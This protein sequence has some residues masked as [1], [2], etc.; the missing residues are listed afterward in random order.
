VDLLPE[1]PV[2][3]V[4]TTENADR[5]SPERTPGAER[6]LPLG[7]TFDDVLLL[8]A[9][10]DVVPS[11]ADT[12]TRRV[13]RSAIRDAGYRMRITT[14]TISSIGRTT[15]PSA[16]S[17]PVNRALTSLASQSSPI[18]MNSAALRRCAGSE[19]MRTPVT[20][21]ATPMAT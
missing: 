8:P 13:R 4:T 5:L 2:G 7:L 6:A 19:R 15:Q 1:P 11:A 18:T 16:G 3:T 12:T 9:E 17:T 21:N 10:S 14:S 20:T